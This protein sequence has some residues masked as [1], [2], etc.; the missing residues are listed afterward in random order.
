LK[1]DKQDTAHNMTREILCIS[2]NIKEIYYEY[3]D[4]VEAEAAPPP[5]NESAAASPAVVAAPVA[6]AVS[7]GPVAAV[8]DEPLK[9]V[10]TLRVLVAQGL[11]KPLDDVPLSKA[12]KDLVGGKSTLQNELLGSARKFS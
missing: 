7:S 3:E 5:T 10:E 11:K 2:K 6:V 12:I 9:A 4:E 1:Y 8:A